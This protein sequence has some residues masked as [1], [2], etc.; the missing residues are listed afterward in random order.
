MLGCGIYMTK[1]NNRQLLSALSIVFHNAAQFLN[2]SVLR[3]EGEMRW[4][5]RDESNRSKG[6]KPDLLGQFVVVQS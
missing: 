3:A 2:P 4:R 1:P 6:R 5:Y